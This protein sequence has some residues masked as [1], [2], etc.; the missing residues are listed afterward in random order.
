MHVIN[1]L[2]RSYTLFTMPA[3]LKHLYR[4]KGSTIKTTVLHDTPPPPPLKPQP[5]RPPLAAVDISTRPS[6]EPAS[7]HTFDN[8]NLCD[9]EG[10]EGNDLFDSQDRRRHR[11]HQVKILTILC[12]CF[13]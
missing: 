12:W 7:D 13:F 1:V 8:S 3:S 6:E 4:S 5:E 2:V 10:E 11:L 9:V